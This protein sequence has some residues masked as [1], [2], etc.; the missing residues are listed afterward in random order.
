MKFGM[1]LTGY[2]GL[3]LFSAVSA[4]AAAPSAAD[5]LK[6]AT[7][8]IYS[9]NE[10][11]IYVMKLNEGGSGSEIVRKMKVLYKRG[12]AESAKLIIKF[13]E[14]AD[15]RGTGLL[16]IIE[17]DKPA[18]QWIYLPAL[19]KTRRIKGGNESESFLGSDFTVGDLTSIDN[20]AKRYDYQIT[21]A[22]TACGSAHCTV[23]TGM[24]KSGVDVASLPYSKK[25]LF[26][27]ND[28]FV[29]DH[30]EFFNPEGKLEKTLILAN[31]RKAGSS[32]WISDKM[33]MKNLLSGHTT[34]IEVTKRDTSKAPA[35]S[36][37]TQ[38][39]LER[40]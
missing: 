15:I 5:I 16:S 32:G 11:S 19:K 31:L 14:P 10:E 22:N 1:K 40:N 38:A 18:D 2:L 24:P 26:V 7:Q 29:T 13:Q 4:Q 27:R 9:G 6:K 25:V 39:A 21:N 20:D 37:F 30:I 33:E 12:G 28:N 8:S 35:D 34:V 17:K 36:A 3:S 23:L